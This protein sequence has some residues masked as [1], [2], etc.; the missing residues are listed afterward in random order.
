M[1]RRHL[2]SALERGALRGP[3]SLAISA[4]W[5]KVADPVRPAALPSGLHV[6]GVGGATLGGSGKTPVVIELARALARERRVAV[7]ATA[8]RAR[9]RG[10]C[11]VRVD[12]SVDRVGDEAA[13][14]ARALDP[15]PVIVGRDRDQALALAARRAEVAIV[16]GL[17][18]AR[19][20]RVGRSLLVL[21]GDA[22]W[23]AARCPPA[24]DLRASAERVLA[25][26]DVVLCHGAAAVQARV[27]VFRL[28]ARLVGAL[29]FEGELITLDALR[30]RRLG[31]VLAIAR[32]DRVLRTLAAHGIEPQ[33]VELHADH[34]R[35]PQPG[36]AAVDGWLTT[37]KCAT[38]LGSC[39]GGAPVWV[40]DHRVDLPPEVVA[41]AS[42]PA[43]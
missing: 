13:W 11:V 5:A 2:A 36:A 15:T 31:L 26:A 42:T 39:R 10:A 30:G 4:G 6:V 3:V 28:A 23:S 34:A 7:V 18:Q 33:V 21:D 32:P 1:L 27:P 25:A 41:L 17:L 14:L 9:V 12:D 19:P 29:D 40:L 35:I 16:D 8:Y 37:A 38:K 20:Q 43:S 24:G 22:R